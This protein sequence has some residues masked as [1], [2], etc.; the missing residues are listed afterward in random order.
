MHVWTDKLTLSNPSFA[1]L[2]RG[3]HVLSSIPNLAPSPRRLSVHRVKFG[4][5]AGY[6]EAQHSSQFD[7]IGSGHYALIERGPD[8]AQPVRLRTTPDLIK[9]QTYFL[10]GLSQQQLA[11]CIFPLGCLTKVRACG[12]GFGVQSLGGSPECLHCYLLARR[13]LSWG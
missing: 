12:S 2:F 9:D 4:A 13:I 11:R 6:M 1:C 5:F 3:M 7:R 8:A 10:A